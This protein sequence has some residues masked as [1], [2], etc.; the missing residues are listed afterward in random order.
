[1]FKVNF[2]SYIKPINLNY[3]KSVNSTSIIF[4]FKQHERQQRYFRRNSIS[5]AVLI[6]DFEGPQ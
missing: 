6:I 3:E 5:K 1:M 2:K 4:K